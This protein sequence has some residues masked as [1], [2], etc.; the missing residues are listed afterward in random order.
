MR[1]HE[2][3]RCRYLSAGERDARAF[4]L[5]M[6]PYSLPTVFC[7]MWSDACGIV[8]RW[9]SIGLVSVEGATRSVGECLK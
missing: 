2:R 5:T 8:F 1:A 4:F 9:V 7:V 3:R 6:V